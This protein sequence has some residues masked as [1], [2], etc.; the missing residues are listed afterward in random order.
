MST[1][2]KKKDT[3]LEGA[4]QAVSEK[5]VEVAVA[6]KQAVQHE[7]HAVQIEAVSRRRQDKVARL[8]DD[9][10]SLRDVLE[11]ARE[12]RED[13]NRQARDIKDIQQKEML[14]LKQ[15]LY[16]LEFKCLKYT[17]KWRYVVVC[18]V[19]IVFALVLKLIFWLQKYIR[20]LLPR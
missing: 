11:S 7:N 18:H 10:D 4:R 14:A 9:I 20:S 13:S 17:K 1:R 15:N 3:K 2:S 12:W 8:N 6:K 19:W 16:A 5:E